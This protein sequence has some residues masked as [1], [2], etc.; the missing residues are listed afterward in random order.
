MRRVLRGAKEVRVLGGVQVLGQ[1]GE[2]S[3]VCVGRGAEYSAGSR[4]QLAGCWCGGLSA[5]WVRVRD[6]A[7]VVSGRDV[8]ASS[9]LVVRRSSRP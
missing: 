1:R 7:E 8:S 6:A 5:K 4:V 2:Q 9:T 3:T